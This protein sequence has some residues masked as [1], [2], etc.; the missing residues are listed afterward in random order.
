LIV[1]TDFLPV[2]R[3]RRRFAGGADLPSPARQIPKS[4]LL[5]QVVDEAVSGECFL[6]ELLRAAV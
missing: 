1:L 5:L 3:E 2:S 6:D 4:R